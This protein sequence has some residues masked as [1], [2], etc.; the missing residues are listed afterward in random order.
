MLAIR[1]Y[2]DAGNTVNVRVAQA[3]LAILFDRLGRDEPAATIA[4]SAFSPLTAALPEFSAAI[5][6]LRDVPRQPNQRITRPQGQD[7]DHRRHGDLRIRPDRPGP[8]RAEPCAKP[9]SVEVRT[10]DDDPCATGSERSVIDVAVEVA[11]LEGGV[12]D[13]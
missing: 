12:L 10:V 5:A 6:H 9:P 3:Q 4:G 13:A 11:R 7:D 1:N 8:N 2:H